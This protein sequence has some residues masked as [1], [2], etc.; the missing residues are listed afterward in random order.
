MSVTADFSSE[1]SAYASSTTK[2][3][4]TSPAARAT[5]SR[6]VNGVGVPDG[7]FGVVTNTREGLTS[8][9]PCA[10]PLASIEN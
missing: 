9:I 7:L 6:S 10:A 8:R 4:P 1:N 5:S 2:R 3:A